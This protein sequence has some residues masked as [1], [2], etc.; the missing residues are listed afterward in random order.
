MGPKLKGL[1]QCFLLVAP[2]YDAQGNF[3]KVKAR[4]VGDGR[5]QLKMYDIPSYTAKLESIMLLLSMGF[6]HTMIVDIG[7]AYLE[8]SLDEEEFLVLDPY[9]ASW[10]AKA[11][12]HLKSFLTN[13]KKLIARID[14]AL[15]GCKQSAG[16]WY[17]HLI[18]ILE[19]M[20]FK[21]NPVEPCVMNGM[22]DG[23]VVTII[24][25]VD[26]LLVFS[27]DVASLEKLANDLEEQ[28]DEVKYNRNELKIQIPRRG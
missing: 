19:S 12:P 27:D 15:Y 8:A 10:A 28:F 23:S 20:G 1:L 17:R 14:K 22:I 4:L 2:K 18:S 5:K 21:R 9:Q 7:G 13:D 24:I 3:I 11:V 6:K 25:Y 26:D 16:L